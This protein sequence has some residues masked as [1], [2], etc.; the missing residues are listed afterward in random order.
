MENQ[1]LS[2]QHTKPDVPTVRMPNFRPHVAT[3]W[4]LV[5]EALLIVQ[6]IDRQDLRY[7]SLAQWLTEEI[8]ISVSDVLLGSMS[9]TP[10]TDLKMSILP[11]TSRA[12]QPLNN[13]NPIE[14][15]HNHSVTQMS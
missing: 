2:P 11:Q 8:A 5:L 9:D 13:K 12:K 10:Y 7:T 4:F 14:K 15:I 6:K 1:H 3:C